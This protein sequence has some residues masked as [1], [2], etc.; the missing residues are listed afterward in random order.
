MKRHIIGVDP[1]LVHTGIVGI[2]IDDIAQTWFVWAHLITGERIELPSGKWELN[3]DAIVAEA[4]DVIG[5][6]VQERD[7]WI[8][9]YRPRSHFDSDATMGRLVNELKRAIPGSRTL[10]NTGVKKVVKPALMRLLNVWTF[11]T[12][13]HHQDLRSAARI[14]LYGALKDEQLNELLAALVKGVLDREGWR[15]I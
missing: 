13:S 15:E 5:T 6:K 3:V 10:D 2:E 14:G 12:K 8:E 9:A 4:A 11:T 1:G 7:V